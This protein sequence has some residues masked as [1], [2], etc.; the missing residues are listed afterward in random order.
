MVDLQL[1][2]SVLTGKSSGQ[3]FPY[4]IYHFSFSIAGAC[5]EAPVHHTSIT[6]FKAAAKWQMKNDK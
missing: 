4:I 1:L 5:T 2:M 6:D 3:D